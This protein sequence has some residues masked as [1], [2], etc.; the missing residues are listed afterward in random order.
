VRL[1][2]DENLLGL[3]IA[4]VEGDTLILDVAEDDVVLEPTA[5]MTAIIS[6]ATLAAVKNDASELVSMSGWQVA[7]LE[8][9]SAGAGGV[10]AV[11]LEIGDLRV[12]SSGAGDVSL[13][14]STEVLR[15][16]SSGAGAVDAHEL[17]AGRVDVDL[18]GAG[19]VTIKTDGTVDGTLRGAG[20]LIVTGDPTRID[21]EDVGG[22]GV[23][24]R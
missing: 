5:P 14:G 11:D 19:D 23:S 7:A 6:T 10:K 9:D 12:T 2:A 17:S 13:G 16:E 24:I 3:L 1:E 15:L 8:L 22:G 4:R 20:D 18:S 21:V